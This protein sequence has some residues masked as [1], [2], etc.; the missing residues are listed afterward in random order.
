M[1]EFQEKIMDRFKPILNEL[2]DDYN[3]KKLPKDFLEEM[4]EELLGV[5]DEVV[6]ES[7]EV[8]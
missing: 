3:L 6:A 7:E 4:V 8:C 5:V 2:V 1:I